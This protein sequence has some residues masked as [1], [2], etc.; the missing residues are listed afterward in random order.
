MNWSGFSEFVG[1]VFGAPLVMEGLL[2]FF[3]ESTFLG[4]WVFGRDRLPKAVHLACLWL[5]VLG[6]WLSAFFILVANSWMQDPVGFQID[7]AGNAQLD[8]V[9]GVLFRPFTI[10]AWV[11]ALLAGLITASV[12]VFGIAA[13]HLARR[14][15]LQ[16]M[17]RAWRTALVV[18]IAAGALQGGIGDWLGVVVTDRQPMKL[19]AA[20]AVWEDTGPCAGFSI[21]AIPSMEERRNIVDIEIPC[22]LSLLATNSFD[23]SIPGMNPLQVQAE[24]EYGPGNYTPNVWIQFWAWRGMMGFGLIGVAW[25]AVAAWR[26]RRGRLPEGRWFWRLSTWIIPLPF[27]GSML[28]WVVTENGR[29]PWV[30]YGQLKTEDAVSDLSIGLVMTSLATFLVMYTA[31]AIIEIRLIRKVAIAGPPKLDGA[32]QREH[33]G[34]MALV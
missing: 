15:H 7:A 34:P 26:T 2:A 4:L 6:T 24:Q 14:Q 1:G 27:I 28:G 32:G 20:E 11:H 9:L 13:W 29:Q 16:T 30:V 5:F 25:M 33:D 18:G 10:A 21:F 23:G 31:F 17:G 19:A 22:V 8:D 12:V 3:L